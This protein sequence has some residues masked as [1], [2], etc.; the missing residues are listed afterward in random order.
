M[1]KTISEPI[2]KVSEHAPSIL[3]WKVDVDKIGAVIGP[4]GQSIRN[5]SE[6]TG[7]KVNIEDDGS[8]TIFSKDGRQSA[9]KALDMVKAIVSDP[10]VGTVYD[11]TVK[12]IMEFG[13]FI[14]I[15]P[16]KEGLC[17]I[18]KLSEDRVNRVEDVLKEGQKV[19]VRLT[20]IDRMGRLNLSIVDA[21]NPN[22]KPQ[23]GEHSRPGGGGGFNRSHSGPPRRPRH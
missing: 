20:E 7:T 11:G 1:A 18:S 2:G 6:T 19:R 13:A 10:E 16:G 5:I 14:E 8:I 23:A 22:W 3:T 21:D 12:R 9:E 15:L 17:H 4:G